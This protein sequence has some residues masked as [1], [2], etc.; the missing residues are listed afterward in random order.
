VLIQTLLTWKETP[1]HDAADKGHTE[2]A[3]LLDSSAD[4]KLDNVNIIDT[5]LLCCSQDILTLSNCFWKMVLIHIVFLDEWTHHS[6]W[7]FK[8]DIPK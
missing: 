3:R 5:T 7:L 1:L 6:T 8:M 2:I 4:A